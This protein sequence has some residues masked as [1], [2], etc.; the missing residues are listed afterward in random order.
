MIAGLDVLH[1]PLAQARHLASVEEPATWTSSDDLI[2][3]CHPSP[4]G[5]GCRITSHAIGSCTVRV[6]SLSGKRET[7][8][9]VRVGP[10]E[11]VHG[12]LRLVGRD[13]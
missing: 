2:A 3:S 7:I 10:P 8:L 13:I 9:D 12:Q 1:I 11:I 6:T 4:T 5:R